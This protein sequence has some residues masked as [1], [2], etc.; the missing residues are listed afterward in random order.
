MSLNVTAEVVI[1][2]SREDVAGFATDPANDT[3]WIGGIVEAELLTEP[4][5]R[6]GTKV[7]RVAKF[8]GR[9]MEYTPE[10][11]EYEPNSRLVMRTDSPFDMMIAYE[12]ED[13]TAGTLARINIQGGGG[14]F[15]RLAGPLLAQAVKRNIAGDLRRLKKLVESQAD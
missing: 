5:V 12:F 11:I 10:V 15:Y 4:P 7:R 3:A 1:N 8:L 14:G 2:R 9:R 6:V 13:A